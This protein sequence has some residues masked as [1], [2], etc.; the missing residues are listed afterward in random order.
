MCALC[1]K[2]RE[3]T[4]SE[5]ADAP[6]RRRSLRSRAQQKSFRYDFDF[7]RATDFFF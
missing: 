3:P 5:R 4:L 7:A 6:P 1:L 2:M